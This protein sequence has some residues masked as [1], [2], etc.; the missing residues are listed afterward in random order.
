MGEG[1]Y[2][3]AQQNYVDQFKQHLGFQ[4]YPGTL[5]VEIKPI[6]RNK[7]RILRQYGGVLIEEFQTKNRTFGGV[8]CY[9]ATVNGIQ[10]A[11]VIPTRSHY[12]TV[13]EIISPEFLRKVLKVNDGD[14]VDVVVHID[15]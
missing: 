8:R 10:A 6:E 4:P 7:L 9:P 15:K 1:K 5:N 13:L 3:T 14:Q 2:Y 12:S 11:I